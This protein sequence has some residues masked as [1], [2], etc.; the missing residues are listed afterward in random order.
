VAEIVRDEARVHG[1]TNTQPVAVGERE[2]RPV[3]HA[4]ARGGE[5][6]AE[7]V[8]GQEADR[9]G[10]R[11]QHGASLRRAAQPEIAILG[12]SITQHPRGHW[13]NWPPASPGFP[14]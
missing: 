10:A 4:R 5:Q 12:S 13:R 2:Q 3:A 11:P 8:E 1:F 9:V 14:S 6:P 7:F